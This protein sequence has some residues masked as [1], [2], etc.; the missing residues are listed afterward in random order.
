MGFYFTKHRSFTPQELEASL[1][2]RFFT[3][4]QKW[5]KEHTDNRSEKWTAVIA[6]SFSLLALMC[7]MEDPPA[8]ETVFQPGDV[9]IW[10]KCGDVSYLVMVANDYAKEHPDANLRGISVKKTPS[11]GPSAKNIE[12]IVEATIGVYGRKVQLICWKD[13]WMENL[14]AEEN[15]A[16]SVIEKFDISV[17]KVA[18]T[19]TKGAGHSLLVYNEEVLEGVKSLTFTAT[20]FPDERGE[21]FARRVEKYQSR[22]FALKKVVLRKC[23]AS[24]GFQ[25]MNYS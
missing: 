13:A 4:C 2:L 19:S 21:T 23:D 5:L 10:V 1:E 24:Y 17:V 8:M 6:G 20:L 11:Y 12:G 18:I 25:I 22:G 14:G 7:L 3:Y 16:M 9:D 15:L